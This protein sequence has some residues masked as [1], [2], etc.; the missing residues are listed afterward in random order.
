MLISV[1]RFFEPL[2]HPINVVWLLNVLGATLLLW[3]RRWLAALI[4]VATVPWDGPEV[5]AVLPWPRMLEVIAK[6]WLVM[7]H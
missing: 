2:T 7:S 1:L 5:M 4:P 3:K 6:H